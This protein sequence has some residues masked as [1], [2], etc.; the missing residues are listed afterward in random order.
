M[1]DDI[2]CDIRTVAA[3]VGDGIGAEDGEFA[4]IAYSDRITVRVTYG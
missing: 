1:D 2:L 3:V 4:R